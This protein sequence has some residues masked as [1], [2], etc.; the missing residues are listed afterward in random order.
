MV[1]SVTLILPQAAQKIVVS[2]R[3]LGAHTQ[4]TNLDTPF[5]AIRDKTADWAAGRM[6]PENSDEVTLSVASW[7]DAQI[8]V[9]GF[10][11]AYA[12]HAWKLNSGDEIEV[13]VW[14]PQTGNGPGL[15]TL[16]VSAAEPN[17]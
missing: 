8:V 9:A 16:R 3:N 1:T 14:N 10:S 12:T 11:G 4:F 6:T 2:G 13:A 7:T 5:L 17:R 15:Y